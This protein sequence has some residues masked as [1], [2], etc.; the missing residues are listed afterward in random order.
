MN[1]SYRITN[2]NTQCVRITNPPERGDV[3]IRK[4]HY[5]NAIPINL[6]VSGGWNYCSPGGRV[7]LTSPT[8]I[9]YF[10]PARYNYG[11]KVK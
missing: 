6:K 4:V 2:A 1:I 11:F 7:P 9:G 10:I 5:G 8:I 3:Y